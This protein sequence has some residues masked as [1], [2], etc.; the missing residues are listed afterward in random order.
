MEKKRV[1]ILFGMGRGVTRTARNLGK[2]H[3]IPDVILRAP[4][5]RAI[6]AAKR[7]KEMLPNAWRT[8]PVRESGLLKS[9]KSGDF[10]ERELQKIEGANKTVFCVAEPETLRGLFACLSEDTRY[11]TIKEGEA[12]VFQFEKKNWKK[13]KPNSHPD[14]WHTV[15]PEGLH[16]P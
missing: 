7:I 13:V 16:Q 6:K 9:G 3:R 15:G 8:V 5:R 12:L 4:G 1:L 14:F 11:G 10:V 2:L